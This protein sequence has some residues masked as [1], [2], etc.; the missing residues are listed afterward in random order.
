[1]EAH[2]TVCSKAVCSTASLFA[3]YDS[4]ILVIVTLEVHRTCVKTMTSKAPS[5]KHTFAPL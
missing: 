3:N 4:K 1:M 2:A 5:I